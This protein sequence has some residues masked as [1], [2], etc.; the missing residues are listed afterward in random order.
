MFL[1]LFL[2]SFVLGFI[3]ISEALFSGLGKKKTR[4]IW[5]FWRFDGYVQRM[6]DSLIGCSIP[7]SSKLDGWKIVE[8]YSMCLLGMNVLMFECASK[9]SLSHWV[10]YLL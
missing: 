3:S 8:K 4:L 9:G 1:S 6:S 5:V 2:F 7:K 10:H